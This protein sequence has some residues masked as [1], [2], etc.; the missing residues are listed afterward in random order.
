VFN[1][2]ENKSCILFNFTKNF[3][4]FLTKSGKKFQLELFVTLLSKHEKL[5]KRININNFND[6]S[7]LKQLPFMTQ[8]QQG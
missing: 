4:K 8:E 3:N 1:F 6:V 5:I 7:K 2:H